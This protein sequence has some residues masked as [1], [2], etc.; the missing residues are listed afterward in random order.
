VLF[1]WLHAKKH[2]GQFILRYDDT[3]QARSTREFADQ[4][5]VDLNWLGITPDRVERQSERFSLY[6]AAAQKLKDAGLLY[7][8]YEMADELDRKRKRLLARGLPPIYGR[9]GLDQTDEERAGFEAE[10]RKA[11]WRFKLPNHAEGDVH[12]LQRTDV[13]WDDL[14]RGQQSVDLASM[15]DPVLIRGDGSYLYTL[16]SCVDDIDMGVTLIIRGDDHVTNT[17]AQIAIFKALGDHVPSFGH[18]NLLTTASGEGLS[19]RLGSLSLESLAADGYEPMAVASLATL[20]GTS[21]SVQAMPTMEGLMDV[22]SADKSTKSAAKFSVDELD[23]LNSRLVHELPYDVIADRLSAVGV[24]G[25]N[26]EGFWL[27]VRGNVERVEEAAQWWPL[28]DGDVQ[29]V[30]DAEDRDFIAAAEKLLPEGELSADT[31]GEWTKALKAETGRKGRG[32]FMPLRKALT[33]MEHGPEIGPLLPLIRREKIV[34][35]LRG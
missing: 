8:C 22:F 9:E 18:H 17:G 35:R 5:L 26:A 34:A 23:A 13:T 25:E 4:I 19:K 27:T 21:D 7:P 1:N 28:I 3:D 30:I 15:S 16:P 32:L 24:G 11:H 29:P 14:V 10:G 33:G 12:A 6:D 20:I 2:G 31:W